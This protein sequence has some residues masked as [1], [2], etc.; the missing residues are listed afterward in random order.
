[1][2]LNASLVSAG[3]H[4]VYVINEDATNGLLI[5]APSG[6]TINNQAAN[7]PLPIQAN[8]TMHF[9]FKS[10]TAVRSVP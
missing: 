10:T 9:I 6:A 5:Y 8:Q 3:A 4:D 2:I 7:T 1:V